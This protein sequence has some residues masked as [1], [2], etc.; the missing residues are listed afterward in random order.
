MPLI[1]TS[2]VKFQQSV[3]L[4]RCNCTH[5][6]RMCVMQLMRGLADSLCPES[7]SSHSI[8]IKSRYWRCQ[9]SWS[10]WYWLLY[11]WEPG[12][13]LYRLDDPRFEFQQKQE[14]FLFFKISKLDLCPTQPPMGTWAL[15]PGQSDRSVRLTTHLHMV[16]KFRMNGAVLRYHICLYAVYREYFTFTKCGITVS[17]NQSRR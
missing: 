6:C 10:Q 14:I 9:S 11:K 16:P 13:L 4:P 7:N 1:V 2:A 17:H 8:C 5:D 15:P 12:Y 3:S